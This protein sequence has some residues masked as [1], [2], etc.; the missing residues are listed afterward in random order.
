MLENN[1]LLK[2]LALRLNRLKWAMLGLK[3]AGTAILDPHCRIRN[4]RNLKLGKK[5]HL[6]PYAYLFCRKGTIHIGNNTVIRDYTVIQS[7]ECVSIGDN[8]LIAP[9]CMITDANHNLDPNTPITQSGRT[10]APVT[11]GNNVWLA[12]GAKVMPG[13]TIGDNA[14]VAAGA[15]VTKDVAPNTVVGGVPAKFIKNRD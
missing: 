12:A 3:G 7:L 10:A 13:V 1:S 9:H 4:P 8:V 5:V 6:W 2:S 11:I 14:V 15:V